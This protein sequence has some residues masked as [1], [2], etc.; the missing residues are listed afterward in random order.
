MHE[1]MTERVNER[2]AVGTKVRKSFRE[3]ANGINC[4]VGGS[5][6]FY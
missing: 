6:A 3:T 2:A 5:R 4:V 1:C